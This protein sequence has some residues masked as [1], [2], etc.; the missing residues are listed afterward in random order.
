MEVN[1][2]RF[3]TKG[4]PGRVYIGVG[5]GRVRKVDHRTGRVVRKRQ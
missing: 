3:R 4:V 5:P 1:V 2:F